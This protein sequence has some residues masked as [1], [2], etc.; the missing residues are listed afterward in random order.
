M[1]APQREPSPAI[2]SATTEVALLGPPQVRAAGQP[3]PLAR[4]QLRALLYRLDAAGPKGAHHV[5][6]QRD[7][8]AVATRS[9]STIRGPRAGRLC[10][11]SG[12]A[13]LTSSQQACAPR[14][15]S[16]RSL[17]RLLQASGLSP[18][19]SLS[20]ALRAERAFKHDVQGGQLATNSAFCARMLR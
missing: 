3:L 11:K 15:S 12:C 5:D 13:N 9:A 16:D 19:H 2:G 10:I 7:V 17:Q 14:H 1:E 4:R 8:E 6:E 18:S 20:A